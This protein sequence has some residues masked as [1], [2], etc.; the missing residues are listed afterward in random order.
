VGLAD[1]NQLL[2]NSCCMLSPWRASQVKA[3]LHAADISNPLR[4]WPGALAGA[5]RVHAEFAQQAAQERLQQLPVAPHMEA[6]EPAVWARMEVEFIDYVVGPLWSR[7]SQVGR[8]CC[9]TPAAEKQ[10]AAHLCLIVP[11]WHEQVSLWAACGQ[12]LLW[13]SCTKLTAG[14]E[15]QLHSTCQLQVPAAGQSIC[16]R[17]YATTMQLCWPGYCWSLLLLQFFPALQQPLQQMYDNRAKFMAMAQHGAPEAPPSA[18]SADDSNSSSPTGETYFT[19]SGRRPRSGGEPLLQQQ[20]QGLFDS[21]CEQSA[22]SVAEAL[23]G[24]GRRGGSM[25]DDASSSDC[26]A[27]SGSAA[28]SPADDRKTGSRTEQQACSRPGCNDVG[29]QNAHG[30]NQ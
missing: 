16:Y 6:S 22:V 24:T 15:Q 1:A 9:A 30:T 18:A 5:E 20:Q 27:G 21:S 29:L 4:P 28:G 2:F 26:D 13:C 19:G 11:I 7:L 3:I 12:R 8:A 10:M 25:S 23:G 17:C 14:Q